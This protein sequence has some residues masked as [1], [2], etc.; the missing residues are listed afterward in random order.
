[1]R[2]QNLH[3]DVSLQ[4]PIERFKDRRHTSGADNSLQ[5]VPSGQFLSD[6]AVHWV[7]Q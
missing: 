5:L 2:V 6:E 4:P 3:G 1:M 7:E